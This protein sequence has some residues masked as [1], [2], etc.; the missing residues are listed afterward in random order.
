MQ[1]PKKQRLHPKSKQCPKMNS[2]DFS[3]KRLT[4]SIHRKQSKAPK[5]SKK[6]MQSAVVVEPLFLNGDREPLRCSF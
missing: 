1:C 4:T 2:K 5:K 6:K 3:E